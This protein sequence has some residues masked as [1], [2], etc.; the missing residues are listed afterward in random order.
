MTEEVKAENN[1]ETKIVQ[2][3]TAKTQETAQ[4]AESSPDIKSETNK[5]NWKKFRE[6]RENERKARIEAE[7]KAEQTR[8]EAEALK[9]AMESLLNNGQS[10][11]Q[12][13]S[14]SETEEDIIEKKV[15]VA[16]EKERQKHEAER[17]QQEA[18]ELP[19]MLENTYRDFNHV[20]NTENLDYLEYHYPEVAAGY[21]YMP[22]GFDKWSAIYQAVKRFVPQGHKEDLKR[23]DENAMKPKTSLPSGIDTKPKGHPWILT[24]ERRAANWRRMQ[25]EQRNI[26]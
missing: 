14:E 4:N 15:R 24:E 23:I 20:C 9:A 17:K 16:L 13:H 21:R 18:K 6:E 12:M 19:K 22:E 11:N 7:Q 10:N 26:S 5:E 1:Q 3:E 8:K 25:Q 2:E